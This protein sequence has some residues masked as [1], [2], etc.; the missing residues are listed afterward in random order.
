MHSL[1]GG[2]LWGKIKTERV[3]SFEAARKLVDQI[4]SALDSLGPETQLQGFKVLKSGGT[5][6]SITAQPDQEIAAQYGVHAKH[7]LVKPDA[8]QLKKM[9]DLVDKGQLQPIVS[10]ILPLADAA[11]A[12]RL[13]A[14]NRTRGKI[15]LQVT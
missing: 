15:V 6:I 12:H 13:G 8:E 2:S 5:L 7:V 1:P 4:T 10:H 14:T 3:L 11:E 9:A